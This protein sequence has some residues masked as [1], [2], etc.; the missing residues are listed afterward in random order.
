MNTEQL[1][2][3]WQVESNGQVIDTNFAEITSWIEDDTLLRM[4]RVR[5]GNLRWIE[6][7]RV[8]ALM[9]VFNAK[10]N[11]QPAPPV[12]STTKMEP[13][14]LAS[15]HTATRNLMPESPPAERVCAVHP[16]A[17]AD[18]V[19]DTCGSEFCRACPNSYGGTVKICPFCGAMC[20]PIPSASTAFLPSAGR[21]PAGSYAPPAGSFGFGDFANALAH[22]LK[23][24]A[25]LIIGA[26]MYMVFSI[27]Q[28]SMM[29]GGFVL[30]GSALF[31]FL[32]ANMLTVGILTNTVENFT[33]G[34]LDANFMPS[35]DDFDIWEDVV[36]PFFLSIGVY[37]VSF[38]PLIAIGIISVFM[39]MNTAKA[40]MN[41]LQNGAA[42]TAAPE[43]SYAANAAK[44][45]ERVREILQKN[46]DEQK[47]RVTAMDDSSADPN[48][49]AERT[50]P[51]TADEYDEA[52]F[53]EMQRAIG[54]QRKAQLESTIGKTPETLAAERAQFLK[55]IIGYGAL[56]L[57]AGGLALIWGLFYFPAACAVAG[58]TR[59]FMATIN[60]LVGI[61]TIRR[62]GS[63]Y[64]LILVMGLLLVIASSIVGGILSM[65]FSPFDLPSLGNLPA[66]ALASIFGFYVSVVFSCVIGYALYKAADRLNLA[67]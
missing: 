14:R 30:M 18:L 46:A 28:S 44:Q 4:D 29:F 56:F 21:L 20:K 2:E 36:H 24:K 43:I 40:E 37:L 57:V 34:K 6:A 16:D 22:P 59:S 45:S 15:Q 62:L 54:Q 19:C 1:S 49:I 7:G 52:D 31:C 63:S 65:V 35:F 26:L 53:E 33:Q 10:E 38:G 13:T 32:L 58:Y 51:L 61:D 66:K 8:P 17:L 55:T 48:T 50:A 60:P 39:V 42:R 41:A 5:K 25:S 3:K 67:R 11:G 47:R 64:V 12:I 27:G 9:A 23:F